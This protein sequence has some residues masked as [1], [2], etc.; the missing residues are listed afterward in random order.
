M[1][2]DQIGALLTAAGIVIGSVAALV[3]AIGALIKAARKPTGDEP[4]PQVGIPATVP[5]DEIDFRAYADALKRADTAEAWARYWMQRAAGE[6]PEPP[7]DP[8][9][10]GSSS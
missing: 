4:A 1:Q 8:G 3:T 7:R 6:T 2:P 10:P 5:A 9:T